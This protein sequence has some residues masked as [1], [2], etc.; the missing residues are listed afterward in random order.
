MERTSR[1][2][3]VGVLVL[4]ALAA[5]CSEPTAPGQSVASVDASPDSGLV[6]VS[7]SLLARAVAH[8]AQGNPVVSAT[9]SWSSHDAR[10]ARV[11]PIGWITGVTGG[12]TSI[13]ADAAGARDSVTIAVRRR[14]VTAL[15]PRLDTLV[16]IRQS[17][18]LVASTSDAGG[19]VPGSYLWITRDTGVV[20][21][22]QD[23]RV[24][25]RASG[26]TWVVVREDG[27]SRDSARVVVDQ[28]AAR[29]VV[30]PDLASRPVARTQQFSAVAL[31]SGGTAVAGLATTWS[32]DLPALAVVDSAGLATA[33]A[34]GTDTIRAQMGGV[35]GL[36]VLAVR[37]LPVLHLTRDTFD[38]GVGQYPTNL[39]LPAPRVVADSLTI[40]EWFYTHLSVADTAIAVATDSLPVNDL[41]DLV[42]RKVG[43]TTLTASAPRYVSTNAAIRVSRPRLL[44][45]LSVATLA[46]N[47][48]QQLR[49]YVTDSLG[50]HHFLV[51]PL[52]VTAKSSD[53]T[54][55]R[56]QADTL[57]VLANDIGVNTAVLPARAGAAW[58]V[59]EAP[60][61]RPDS[62]HFVIVQPRLQFVQPTGTPL[63]V[64]TIG[65]G[66]SLGPP[67]LASVSAGAP[68]LDTVSI[69]IAQRH[70]ELV[71]IPPNELQQTVQRGTVAPLTWSGTALGVD[72]IIASAPGYS[73]DTLLVYVTRPRYTACGLSSAWRS[74]QLA[75]ISLLPADSTGATHSL[76]APV[77][78][79]V[80][81]SDTTVLKLASDTV[82]VLN[83]FTCSTGTA[84]VV[85]KRVGSATLT[86]TDPAGVYATLVTPPITVQ[87]APLV[88]GLVVSATPRVS[89][90]MHQRLSRD[91]IPFVG[92]ADFQSSPV[93]VQLRSTNPAVASVSPS[94]MVI[95]DGTQSF[96]ITGGDT[97]GTA[98]IVA[99]GPAVASDSMLIDVGRPQFVV[100]GRGVGADTIYAIAVEVRDQFGNRRI[101]TEPVVATITS[102]NF[103]YVVADSSTLTVPDGAEASGVSSVRYPAP[104]FGILRASDPRSAYYRYETGSTGVLPHAP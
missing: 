24:T 101:T 31:D 103:T 87:P 99:E 90:G 82:S 66:Q 5:A 89:L 69:S 32:S 57:T 3:N 78:A 55:L 43:V 96:E 47:E 14:G 67:G 83:D 28:R 8:D 7:D 79:V 59:Y 95:T 60:G 36:A 11:S 34:T 97:T 40:D 26:A 35:S 54:V 104:G 49:I 50:Q 16:F 72:T 9:I 33:S 41:F 76:A 63:S 37:P 92:V 19:P 30:T 13:I 74:D 6:Y 98:W 62:V 44:A 73:P 46:T 15:S 81:S 29:V 64:S 23:G 20:S 53:T 91:S 75:S 88:M 51:S 39:E 61:Y 25:A 70:P 10:V 71:A 45:G 93:A 65:V 17:H 42:G 38:L 2:R 56:P 94:Q 80:T 27:G 68:G 12:R 48:V 102:S 86:F 18:Q 58:M 4:S 52:T 77:R 85:L 22:T 100:R 21:V 1:I 84:G